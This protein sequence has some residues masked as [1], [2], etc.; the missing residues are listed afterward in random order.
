MMQEHPRA[1]GENLPIG[2]KSH[3][4]RG[5]SPRTRGK[6]RVVPHAL[7]IGRNI[8]AHAGKTPLSVW[9]WQGNDG[10]SPRTRGKPG[11]LVKA[12][13]IVRNIPA[14]AGKTRPLPRQ[15][16]VFPEHPRAR[17]ENSASA[18]NRLNASGTSPRTRGK[19]DPHQRTARTHG[20]I[21]AH[22]GKTYD[23]LGNGPDKPEH[24]RAR[25]ENRTR[26]MRI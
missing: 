3:F 14:H 22:A 23:V 8:P 10:T 2:E 21:P 9:I 4:D 19:R 20:N 25:G 15:P 17:G 18:L 11:G 13:K 16:W 24:P 12:K 7:K 5:T 6:L 1:R 26:P